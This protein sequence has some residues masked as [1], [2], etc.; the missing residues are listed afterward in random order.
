MKKTL[1][2][3]LT[4]ISAGVLALS[5]S[6]FVYAA[7]DIVL[8][9][10][11][12]P[13]IKTFDPGDSGDYK[14]LGYAYCFEATS[15]YKYLQITYT[16]EETAFDELRLE[17][18]VNSD[19]ADEIKLTPKWFRENDEGTLVT[20]DGE[21]V[22]APSDEEQTV[23]IDLEKSGVDL[24]TGIRAFHI[25][26]TP[27]KGTFKIIDARLMTSAEGAG[28]SENSDDA[29]DVTTADSSQDNSVS[30]ETATDSAEG[31]AT[32]TTGSTEASSAGVP[33]W[34]IAAGAG[35]VIVAAIAF[36][37]SKSKK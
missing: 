12:S 16:G 25:H 14:Y 33:V 11:G 13:F 4:I 18:V 36:G 32:G 24:S 6:S 15:D 30:L 17:F 31:T 8:D 22:P 7:D 37:V 23:V 27:G 2:K 9:D 21:E 28:N 19:P 29:E 5:M 10:S 20:V 3:L 1:K 35:A 26:D 34:P